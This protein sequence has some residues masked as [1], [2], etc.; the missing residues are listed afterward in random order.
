LIRHAAM[1]A[2]PQIAQRNPEETFNSDQHLHLLLELALGGELYATYN[3]RNL[4]GQD[5]M[6]MMTMMT[7]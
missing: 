7:G 2:M 5:R 3:K 6:T 1:L 4:W